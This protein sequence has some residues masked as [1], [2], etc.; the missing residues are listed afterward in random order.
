MEEL[1]EEEAKELAT[2]QKNPRRVESGRKG[3]RASGAKKE[4][5][6]RFRVGDARASA[7]GKVGGKIGGAVAQVLRKRRRDEEA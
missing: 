3:G 6:G 1:S 2:Y 7:A 4:N 5:A